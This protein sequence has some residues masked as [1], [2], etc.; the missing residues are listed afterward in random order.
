MQSCDRFIGWDSTSL[1]D[2]CLYVSCSLACFVVSKVRQNFHKTNHQ[3]QETRKAYYYYQHLSQ[4][5]TNTGNS[6]SVFQNLCKW[7]AP[8]SNRP[9]FDKWNCGPSWSG[10]YLRK[11]LSKTHL[12]IATRRRWVFVYALVVSLNDLCLS[13]QLQ[14]F[15]AWTTFTGG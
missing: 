1:T 10:E 6:P 14:P 8:A 11:S 3:H 12:S 7:A 15:P 4:T 2:Y 9:R 13:N 5:H